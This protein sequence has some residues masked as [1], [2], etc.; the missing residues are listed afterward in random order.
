LSSTGAVDAFASLPLPVTSPAELRLASSFSRTSHFGLAEDRYPR[1]AE[2]CRACSTGD[3]T[4]AA[5]ELCIACH[6]RG[7]DFRF[8]S[9]HASRSSRRE[10]NL[11][12][13]PNLHLP[14]WQEMFFPNRYVAT[15]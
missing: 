5:T 3:E 10:A 11:R 15:N 2:C 12:L 6:H 8:P 13:P 14:A 7:W 4:P 9:N 1:S